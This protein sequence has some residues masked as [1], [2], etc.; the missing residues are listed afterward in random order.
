MRFVHVLSTV[1][2]AAALLAGCKSDK[3][4]ADTTTKSGSGSASMSAST[5]TPPRQNLD[6]RET[7]TQT[8]AARDAS[9]DLARQASGAARETEAAARDTA[10]AARDAAADATADTAADTKARSETAGSTSG[11]TAG[12]TA[13]TSEA[14]KLLDQATQYVKENKMDL[15]DKTLTQLEGMK[16][17]LP[18]SYGSKIDAARSMFNTAQKGQGLLGG[19][20]AK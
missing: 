10:G 17:Q 14:Q 12:A 19:A 16:P 8:D 6:F 9:S 7:Q 20:G 4:P 15:A 1:A 13:D 2:I 18:S 11:T 5:S 3:A